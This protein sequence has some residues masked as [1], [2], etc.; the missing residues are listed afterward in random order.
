MC[1]FMSMCV[2]VCVDLV[3]YKA[4]CACS[5]C[6]FFRVCVLILAAPDCPPDLRT[7]ISG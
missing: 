5:V 3:Q 2:C 7:A 6:V 1:V 4:A